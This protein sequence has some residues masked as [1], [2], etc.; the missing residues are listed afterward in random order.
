MVLVG[1]VQLLVLVELAEVEVRVVDVKV[2][3][4]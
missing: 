3:M 1:L 4:Q 2:M